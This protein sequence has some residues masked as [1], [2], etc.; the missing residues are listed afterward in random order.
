MCFKNSKN[1]GSSSFN[2]PSKSLGYASRSLSALSWI[3][4]GVRSWSFRKNVNRVF[5]WVYP[6][7]HCS[8]AERGLPNTARKTST[9]NRSLGETNGHCL[10]P[11]RAFDFEQFFSF[12]L[13]GNH[14]LESDSVH[15]TQTYRIVVWNSVDDPFKEAH[16]AEAMLKSCCFAWSEAW[17]AWKRSSILFQKTLRFHFS[18]NPFFAKSLF[19]TPPPV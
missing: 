2:P 14:A 9:R 8:N 15:L 4:A 19:S 10:D 7:R 13:V 16:N 12:L 6:L 18:T 3:C 11:H 5:N 17:V 1:W